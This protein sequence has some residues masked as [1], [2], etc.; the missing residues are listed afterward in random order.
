[1]VCVLFL[2]ALSD[3]INSLINSIDIDSLLFWFDLFSMTML[4]IAAAILHYCPIPLQ[5][6]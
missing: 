6:N 4:Q 5:R 3:S 1:M 2:E